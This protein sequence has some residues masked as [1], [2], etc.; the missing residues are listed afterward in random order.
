MPK[1]NDD[2]RVGVHASGLPTSQR[3]NIIGLK[4]DMIF[5]IN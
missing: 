4:A 3:I 1:R 5:L 2:T